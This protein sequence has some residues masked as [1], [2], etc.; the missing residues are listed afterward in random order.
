MNG[1][2]ATL[3]RQA[4]ETLKQ[5]GV[6]SARCEA[7]WLLGH[8]LKLK[9][10]ELYLREERVSKKVLDSFSEYV[11]ARSRGIPLQ[12]LLGQTEFYGLSLVVEPGVFIPRPE[13]ES[14]VEQALGRFARRQARLGRPLRLLELG[15]GSG[16]IAIALASHLSSCRVVAIEVSWTALKTAAENIRRQHLSARVQLVGGSWMTALRSGVLFDAIISNP[17]YVASAEVDR[18]PLDVRQEPRLSLDG[19]EDGL[20][21]IRQ[22]VA[23]AEQHLMPGGMLIIECGESQVP[24]LC[25][26]LKSASY[27]HAVEPVYD[28]AARPRGLILSGR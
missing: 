20:R 12:Y 7:E 6:D 28:L 1:S 23:E 21:D 15:A 3:I 4:T 8:L 5:A 16:A 27:F 10:T 19:G 11:S 2:A 26:E 24:V 9:P 14:V 25:D 13:T 18:L 17:P 22:L